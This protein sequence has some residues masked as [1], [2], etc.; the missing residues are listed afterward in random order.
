MPGRLL[1]EWMEY[2]ELE[3]WGAWRDNF[4]AALIASLLANKDRPSSTP[5]VAVSTFFYAD[6]QTERERKDQRML[7]AFRTLKTAAKRRAPG[8]H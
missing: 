2:E 3:P 7:T 8:G 1:A 5:P 6:P 4:H